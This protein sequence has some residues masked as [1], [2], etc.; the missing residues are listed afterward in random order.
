[1]AAGKQDRGSERRSATQETIAH[2]LSERQEMWVL[3][4]RLA[5]VD[6]YAGK[7]EP[8]ALKEFIQI[9]IDYISAADFGLYERISGG[10]E[11]RKG[12]DQL[13]Q[14]LYPS[15]ASTTEVAIAFN[16]K[17]AEQSP[18]EVSDELTRDLSKLGENLASRI[19][20]EDQL[21]ERLLSEERRKS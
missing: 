3:Y 21:I 11:R 8:M 14:D 4:E 10:T 12:V 2:L 17:Y 1:M 18:Q 20:H 5:G 13:A 7:P 16:D 9:L 6:P 15:I 19:E